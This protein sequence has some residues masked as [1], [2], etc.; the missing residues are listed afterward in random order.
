MAKG[1]EVLA[2]EVTL[3]SAELRPLREV[4]EALSKLRRA[5]KTRIRQGRTLNVEE[6]LDITA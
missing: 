2:H 6:L 5:R 1:I 3:L 4:N